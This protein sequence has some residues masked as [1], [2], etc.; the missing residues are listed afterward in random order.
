MRALMLAAAFA[1][2]FTPAVALDDPDQLVRALYRPEGAPST[3]PELNRFFDADLARALWTDSQGEE[4]G[5]VDF[6][7]RYDA[8][9]TEIAG[10][11]FEKAP[12]DNGATVT[13]SFRNF[14]KPVR[15]I[16]RLCVRGPGWRIAEVSAGDGSWSLRRMLGLAPHARC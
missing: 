8:Q 11:A 4:V 15:V 1:L 14:G 16:Y 13:A 5:A 2:A 6:D 12:R 3:R 10:L 7:F 9:D